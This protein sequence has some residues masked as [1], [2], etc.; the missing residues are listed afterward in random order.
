MTIHKACKFVTLL[1]VLASVPVYAGPSVLQEALT[2]E[3]PQVKHWDI[4]P[5][6]SNSDPRLTR[7][8][9]LGVRSAAQDI[10]GNVYW[11]SVNGQQDVYVAA[12]PIRKGETI[13]SS[14][15]EKV[16]KNIVG[17]PCDATADLDQ[18]VGQRT[19]RWISRGDTLCRDTFEAIPDVVRGSRINI[20]LA[21]GRISLLAK[22]EALA[23]ANLG[24]P[25]RVRNP[26]SRDTF[27]AFVIGTNE[28]GVNE[29]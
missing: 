19:S 24:E 25:V 16:S 22:V 28:V 2:L 12:V 29:K 9:K 17:L 26:S 8:I 3:F 18:I 23:D 14:Q 5:L 1:V 10:V 7:V 13:S 15:L 21:V 4:R 27:V 11:F 6:V 20:R